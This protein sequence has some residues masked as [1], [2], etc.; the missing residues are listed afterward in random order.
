MDLFMFSVEFSNKRE[1]PFK[2]LTGQNQDILAK[3]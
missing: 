3:L 2:L 1:F